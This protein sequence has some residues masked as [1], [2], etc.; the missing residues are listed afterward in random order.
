MGTIAPKFGYVPKILFPGTSNFQRE[1]K[2]IY[3]SD[4][5]TLGVREKQLRRR[6]NHGKGK[7]N[8]APT[9]VC[10]TVRARILSKL[11]KN[12]TAIYTVSSG[13]LLL[14]S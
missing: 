3:S 13:T 7:I 5:K 10:T 8:T 1:N 6:S 9:N 4:D 11:T 12:G 2:I 14:N